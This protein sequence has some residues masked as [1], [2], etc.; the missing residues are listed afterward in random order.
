MA[1]LNSI[2]SPLMLD[3]IQP[4]ATITPEPKDMTLDQA[5]KVTLPE[6]KA[7]N[8]TTFD[9]EPTFDEIA[10]ATAKTFNQSAFYYLNT[11]FS[12]LNAR[13]VV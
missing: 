11:F 13:V 3:N 6:L 4:E 10:K 1:D 9:H 2:P 7:D 5:L 12:A 8:K